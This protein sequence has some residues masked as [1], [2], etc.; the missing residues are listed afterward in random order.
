MKFTTVG[1]YN[2]SFDGFQIGSLHIEAGMS[3]EQF[4]TDLYKVLSN[5][6]GVVADIHESAF[7]PLSQLRDA[8]SR[9]RSGTYSITPD[10]PTS[11]TTTPHPNF[12]PKCYGENNGT[13][14]RQCR[15][16]EVET[17]MAQG[18][19]HTYTHTCPYCQC[20]IS[21]VGPTNRTCPDCDSPM[22]RSKEPTA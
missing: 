5:Q 12:C 2:N 10:L 6:T 8:I 4:L 18:L 7:L 21:G 1:S 3:D 20:C 15:S 16:G 19:N 14:C 9:I 11:V 17:R 13:I 22:V